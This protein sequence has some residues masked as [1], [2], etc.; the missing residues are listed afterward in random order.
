M[1]LSY[2]TAGES[3][4]PAMLALVEGMPAGVPVDV[5]LIDAELARRQGG[6]GR[7]ARER[8]EQD[9]MPLAG[10]VLN[11]VQQVNL[12]QV[13]PE[14][15]LAA[16]ERLQTDVDEAALTSALLRLHAGRQQIAARQRHLSAR[17]TAAHPGV[18]ATT[19]PALAEDVHDLEGLRE[20]G[21]YLAQPS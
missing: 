21:E 15:A 9:N 2:R 11:R 18:P 6:Y 4:G 10:L 7:G 12:P 16:A 5:A 17:F 8:L 3:H 1:P 20:I 14:Q 13:G 19:V